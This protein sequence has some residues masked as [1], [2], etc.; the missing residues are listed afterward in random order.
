M[1]KDELK[2]RTK[3]YGIEIIKFLYS[4]PKEYITSALTNQLVRSAT[5]I[6]AN[7]RAALR[8]RS[9]K[10]F[11]A[12]IGIIVEEADETLYWLEIMKEVPQ[13][14]MVKNEIDLLMKEANELTAIFV[15]TLKTLKSNQNLKS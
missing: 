6:G 5:S 7:Y 15:S 4:L 1:T 9:D 11:I 2:I 12:K 3:K 8:S 14:N 10:E 13:F